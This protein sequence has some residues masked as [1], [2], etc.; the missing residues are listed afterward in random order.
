MKYV[1][2]IIFVALVI[3]IVKSLPTAHEDCYKSMEK[4]GYAVFGCC[5]GA[6]GG[7]AAT[8]YLSEMCI[9]CPYFVY[10]SRKE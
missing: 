2:T 4:E 3:W 8:E 6:V 9:G 10:P 7:T 1:I 5:G